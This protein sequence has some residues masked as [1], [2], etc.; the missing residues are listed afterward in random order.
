MTYFMTLDGVCWERFVS[1][2][3]LSGVVPDI[4]YYRL[5]KAGAAFV[6]AWLGAQP[7]LADEV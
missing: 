2:S 1:R 6:D 5:T 7:L 4:A 3:S